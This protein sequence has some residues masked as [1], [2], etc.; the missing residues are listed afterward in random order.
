MSSQYEPGQIFSLVQSNRIDRYCVSATCTLI[1]YDHV[2]TLSRELDMCRR[3]KRN[4]VTILFHLNRWTLLTWALLNIVADFLPLGTLPRCIA[5]NDIDI[6]AALLLFTL[7]AAFSAIRTY[8]MSGGNRLLA[9]FVCC[10]G[11]V[12]V[13]TNAYN[14]FWATTYEIVVIPTVGTQCDA[15]KAITLAMN[16]KFEVGTRICAIASDLIVLVATWSKTYALKR[17]TA[18]HGARAP[19]ATLLLRDGTL[20]F[21]ALL[22]LNILNIAGQST[23]VFVYAAQFTV[24]LSSIII[25]HFFLNLHQISHPTRGDADDS[26]FMQQSS[27]RFATFVGNMGEHLDHGTDPVPITD[28]D[29]DWEPTS[30]D[31]VKGLGDAT[32]ADPHE[33]HDEESNKTSEVADIGS[34]TARPPDVGAEVTDA[35]P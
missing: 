18:L 14:F 2:R 4:C 16:T 15:G 26:H 13:A 27:L 22:C 19:L 32:R 1:V 12:P 31:A 23:N 33:Q 6:A 9:L 10:L 8:A 30:S 35:G 3:Q 24:P 20:Y 11:L 29:L 28:S 25:T 34:A 21:M 5:L 7:W 17:A